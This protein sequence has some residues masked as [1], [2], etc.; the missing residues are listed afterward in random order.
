MKIEIDWLATLWTS[1][2]VSCPICKQ[3]Y[4][5]WYCP[6]CGLPKKNSKFALS[7]YGSVENCRNYHFRPE[8]SSFEDFQLCDK[9]YTT[10][11]FDAKY[12][13]NCS[14]KINSSKGIDKNAHKWVDLG[15]SVLW[16]EEI[17]SD[18]YQ[19]MSSAYINRNES[20]PLEYE[21]DGKDAASEIWGHKWR[22]PTK[23]EFEELFT[24]CRWERCIDH[25]SKNYALKATGPNGNSIMLPL[26]SG[27][28]SLWTST[29]YAAK[30]NGEVAY[31][32]R[33]FNDIKIE[34][35]LTAKQKKEIEFQKSN[36]ARFK[37]DSASAVLYVIGKTSL[38]RE[39]EENEK[40]RIY[41]EYERTIEQQR[42]IL[43]VM[44]D[45]SQER[46]DN[47]KKDKEKLDK[48]WLS[49]PVNL[50]FNNEHISDNKQKYM[51]K[52]FGLSILPV[53]DK[54]WKGKL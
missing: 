20:R 6:S 2:K 13:R 54:K 46:R 9:C 28:I 41:P 16:S 38:A 5:G 8:F 23:D 32:F 36:A 17:M 52:R 26:K 35:T 45:D 34:K 3:T 22:T 30:F 51:P 47:E 18:T 29:E 50:S 27:S 31:A 11:P 44:G 21:G 40:R 53:A 33:F 39:I 15:L 37:V 49:T 48:L 25:I 4:S 24:K 42:Q 1:V 14:E 7:E 10:N 43:E 19:W 12:C